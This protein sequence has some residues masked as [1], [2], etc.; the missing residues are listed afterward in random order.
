MNAEITGRRRPWA[1]VVQRQKGKL[2]GARRR[3]LT[4]GGGKAGARLRGPLPLLWQ[5]P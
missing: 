5:P 1:E 2:R 4:E 3:E